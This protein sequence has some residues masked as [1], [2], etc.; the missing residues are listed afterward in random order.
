MN[1]AINDSVRTARLNN[2]RNESSKDYKGTGKTV[3]D[4]PQ[5]LTNSGFDS[6][7]ITG[8][9]DKVQGNLQQR[10]WD[11]DGGWKPAIEK[12][13]EKP[14]FDLKPAIDK[15]VILKPIID[16]IP[17]S[18]S[19]T[20]AAREL[21]TLLKRDPVYQRGATQ[22]ST[23]TSFFGL[24]APDSTLI[25]TS[26]GEGFLMADGRAFVVE[27]GKIAREILPGK[28]DG[29]EPDSQ[30]AQS[31]TAELDST[32]GE[33]TIEGVR[34]SPP[35]FD[36]MTM[37]FSLRDNEFSTSEKPLFS[38]STVTNEYNL[39]TGK[40]TS[41]NGQVQYDNIPINEAYDLLA[42]T[43]EG[44]ELIAREPSVNWEANADYK[45]LF[46]ARVRFERGEGGAEL[47]ADYTPRRESLSGDALKAYDTKVQEIMTKL[48]SSATFLKA[49]GSTPLNAS[50]RYMIAS[51]LV[52]SFGTDTP[53]LNTI[54]EDIDSWVVSGD[55]TE[56]PSTAGGQ[57]H[58]E[59]NTIEL[60]LTSSVWGYLNTNDKY[61]ILTH[62]AAHALDGAGD[63]T[64][65]GF[66]IGMNA[67]DQQIV[68]D[69]YVRLQAVYDADN[70][71]DGVADG[72][73]SGI[74]NYPFDS[75]SRIEFWA[76]VSEL[77]L[78][79]EQGRNGIMNASPALYAVL[80]RYYGT[81][82]VA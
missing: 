3:N 48:E 9:L 4:A 82:P 49:T 79:N 2:N 74:T 29:P 76:T 68:A 54:V 71:G 1:N 28:Q 16:S 38:F 10:P 11:D 39:S 64:V 42:A 35:L 30:L 25:Q 59:S 73:N 26:P 80:E 19:S 17:T 51:G 46:I 31:P 37:N 58:N 34:T 67:T 55:G 56:L 72:D 77:Y 65:D 53:A 63:S 18:S 22:V 20:I 5:G 15:P 14:M 81:S 12:P 45:K 50:H 32:T 70:N 41:L 52:E 43:P 23:S 6:N 36:T 66:G 61:D 47:F 21:E 57:Y 7:Q 27:D 78:D 62:E 44:S 33:L 60:L 13:I 24:G 8:V 69:E 40:P 75:R